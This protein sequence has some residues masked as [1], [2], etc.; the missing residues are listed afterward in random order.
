PAGLPEDTMNESHHE[1]P[2]LP[3][4]LRGWLRQAVE[5]GASDL[6]L[7]VG[8][9]PVLRL[10][11]DLIEQPGPA[12]A[13]DE[14]QALL[15][16]VCPPETFARLADQKNTDCSFSLPLGAALCR[17]RA[18][19]FHAGGQLGACLRIVPSSIP[20]LE[21]ADFPV[22][23]AHRLAFLLDGLVIITGATGSGKTT[24][25]AMIVNLLNQTG[26]HRII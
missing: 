4:K 21:W 22:E 16:S 3:E 11:G 19:V 20:D 14:V 25:L 1:S 2:P 9:P 7:V 23:L 24:T 12:L 6:H 17:F 13:G 5:A 26:G 8:H 10:H 15:A 18:N